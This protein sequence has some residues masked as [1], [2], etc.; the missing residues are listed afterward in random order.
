MAD[1]HVTEIARSTCRAFVQFDACQRGGK[2][3]RLLVEHVPYYGPGKRIPFVTSHDPE[4]TGEVRRVQQMGRGKTV[5]KW[6][7]KIVICLF[8]LQDGVTC[9]HLLSAFTTCCCFRSRNVVVF[10]YE[11]EISL[12]IMPCSNFGI[13]QGTIRPYY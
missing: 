2:F 1:S 12:Y 4:G 5:T 6:F 8:S 13:R 10:V 9:L 7:S 3:R 11:C